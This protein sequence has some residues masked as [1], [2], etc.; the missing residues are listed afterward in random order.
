MNR[1]Q[2]S[3]IIGITAIT[4]VTTLALSHR[5]S[6]AEMVN[7]DSPTAKGLQFMKNSDKEGMSCSGCNFFSATEGDQGS[8]IIFNGGLVP[9]TGWCSAF[10][11]KK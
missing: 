7:P 6:G 9:S 5:A 4:P 11:P 1:R 3:K 10:Q 2:F 8:C